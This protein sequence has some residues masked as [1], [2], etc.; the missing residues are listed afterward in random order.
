[1]K[2]HIIAS[3]QPPPSAKPATA[4]ITGFFTRSTVSQRAADEVFQQRR[5][6]R[7]VLHLLD[8][9]TGGEGALVAGQHDGADCCVGVECQELPAQ[10]VHQR[11][12]QRVQR[13][14]AVEADQADP[15]MRFD[16]DVL[17]VG[18]WR[19]PRWRWPA[20]SYRWVRGQ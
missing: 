9:G 17:V 11:V 8:V 3:S 18:H 12:A 1:M 2:S 13:R 19:S 6:M 4:A 14:R 10:F 5:G 7:A 15:A 20:C 16:E